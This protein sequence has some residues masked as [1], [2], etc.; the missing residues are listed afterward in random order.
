LSRLF[1]IT[2]LFLF[3]QLISAQQA[4]SMKV[5]N[6]GDSASPKISK[7]ELYS[8]PR[9]ATILSA[10]LPGAGQV[11]NRKFWKVPVI[12]ALLGGSGY[13]FYTSNSTYNKYRN[14][15]LYALA[16]GGYATV[17]NQLLSSSQLQTEKLDARKN[18][19]RAIIAMSVVYILNIVDANV[20][21]HLRTFDVSDDLSIRVD[22]WQGWGMGNKII[23]GLSLKINFK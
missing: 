3:V 15:Q 13:W 6:I 5:S 10:M 2:A 23:T 21:A 19:D 4:D 20:D 7:K 22:P 17:D 9:M 16:N 14:G 12:Y 1:F 8:K 18:R 11:Y